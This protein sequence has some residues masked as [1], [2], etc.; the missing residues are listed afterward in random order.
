MQENAGES[1]KAKYINKGEVG[2]EV[3]ICNWWHNTQM[4]YNLHIFCC[5]VNTHLFRLHQTNEKPALF[6]YLDLEHHV[7]RLSIYGICKPYINYDRTT[8]YARR[9]KTYLQNDWCLLLS[10]SCC[11]PLSVGVRAQQVVCLVG[12]FCILTRGEMKVRLTFGHHIWP[13]KPQYI[14]KT[15]SRDEREHFTNSMQVRN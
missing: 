2:V 1:Q 10:G 11:F 6:L 4:C 15:W 3:N 14:N 12:L 13:K 9:L 7:L 8:C 5:R